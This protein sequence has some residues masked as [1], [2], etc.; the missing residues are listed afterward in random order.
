MK[1]Y[2]VTLFIFSVIAV[3]ALLCVVF[4]ADGVKAGN[5]TLRF[6]TLTEVL[7]PESSEDTALPEVS[8]EELLAQQLRDMRMQEENQYLDYFHNSNIRFNLP[9]A[10]L[11]WFDD[12]FKAFEH[13]DEERVRVMHYGDS[14]IEGDRI[15]GVIREELQDTFGGIGPGI[16]P[17]IETVGSINIGQSSTAEL[18]RALAFGPAEVRGKNSNYGPMAQV[19]YL[20][21]TITVSVWPRTK[22]RKH[23][24]QF[25]RVTVLADNI[26]SK[27]YVTCKGD[28]RVVEPTKEMQRITFHF[29]EPVERVSL[30]MSGYANLY[31]ILLDGDNGICVDNIPMRGC[32][33]TMFTAINR[34]QLADFYTNENVRLILLEYGG[35]SVPYL[36]TE[37]SI[38]TYASSIDRQIRYLSELAPK[39]RILLIGPSDMSTRIKGSWQTYPML[40]AII[41]SLRTTANRAGAAYWDM[42]QVMGGHNSMAQWCEQ[43]PPLAGSD[44]I[45]F[46]RL[47]GD[48]VADLFCKSLM[49]YYDYYNWR[50]P[51]PQT[52]SPSAPAVTTN[53]QMATQIEQRKP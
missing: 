43:N 50:K 48:R 35:N 21:T 11:T 29:D 51:K 4:P 16:I 1:A 17:V 28:R 37:K 22:E 47:G 14:Q 6:P 27:L 40:P 2:K 18:T 10:D 39:A 46:T 32:S 7:T 49:L 26:G 44:H 13:C 41:D 33:G 20:D 42:Y 53:P 23:C 19:A 8:P 34:R 52:P 31:G 12:L 3:L 15:T 24:H 36:N 30:S 45:H 5:L 38:H 25:T 9:G